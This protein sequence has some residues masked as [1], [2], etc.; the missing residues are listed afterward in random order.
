MRYKYVIVGGGVAAAAAVEG[1]RAHDREGSLLMLSRDNHPPYRRA[2]LS[3]GLWTGEATLESLPIH[4]DSYYVDH[5]VTLEL[6]HDVVEIDTEG[7]RLWDGSGVQYEYEKLLLAT[8]GRPQILDARVEATTQVSYFHTLED[9]I[10]LRA[11]LDRV[12]H[13][14][15]VGAG[16]INLEIATALRRKGIEI[17]MIY[18]EE[19][20]LGRLLP[21]EIGLVIADVCRENGVETVSNDKIAMLQEVGGLLQ[22]Q[23]HRGNMVTSQHAIISVGLNPHT[24]LAEA[25]GLEVDRAVEVDEYTRTTNEHI[26]AAGDCTEFPSPVLQRR[27][28][29]EN[30][31]H[32]R[33][34]GYAAG[35]NMAGAERVYDHIAEYGA[36]FFGV[37]WLAV[38]LIDPVLDMDIVWQAEPRSGIVFY[39]ELDVILGVVFWNVTPRVDAAREWL[40]SAKPTTRAEREQLASSAFEL[41]AKPAE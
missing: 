40:R 23:T 11:T 33:A 31:D 17:T 35:E 2:A 7:R 8:G 15:L 4:D 41:A 29:M 24:G 10:S 34:H 37:G 30:W 36:S 13:V 38:G 5:N 20:P 28:H 19:Y 16:Y 22:G 27:L 9:Y 26:H 32:A 14:L 12:Q 21:R 25:A 1:I 6:R 39:R 18:S 3:K